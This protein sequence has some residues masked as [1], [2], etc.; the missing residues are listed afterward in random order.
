MLK[1]DM[2]YFKLASPYTTKSANATILHHVIFL[3]LKVK[4]KIEM[5]QLYFLKYRGQDTRTMC[6][7]FSK[8]LLTFF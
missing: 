6:L 1:I 2:H 3:H 8:K 7:K 4:N 5:L